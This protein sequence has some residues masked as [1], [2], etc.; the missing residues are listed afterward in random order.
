MAQIFPGKVWGGAEQYV[1]DLGRALVA[2]GHEVEY[3]CLDSAPVISRLN[4]ENIKYKVISSSLDGLNAS[5]D[6]V[7]IHDTRYVSP[8]IKR[9]AAPTK[10]VLTRH[11]AR[12]SRVMPWYRKA[13][14]SLHAMIFVSHLS[15]KMWRGVNSWMPD[16][17][18]CVI[19]NSI[20]EMNPVEMPD[21]RSRFGIGSDLPLL[22]FTGR[23]RRS[24]GCAVI[25][26]A[27]PRLI[28][29]CAVVFVGT[30]KPADY[31]QKL[32]RLAER[33]G[34]SDRIFFYGFT[35]AV[36]SLLPQADIGVQP[37]IVREAFG[38]SQLEFMQAGRPIVTTDNGAQPEYVDDGVTGMLIRP[39]DPEALAE[40]LNRLLEDYPRSTAE[41]GRAAAEA[42]RHNFAYDIFVSNILKVYND[43]PSAI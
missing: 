26:E 41:M 39:D 5:A 23:V 19:H 43:Q 38:L 25:V 31:D 7:H 10:V 1:L 2:Q 27:L 12:A 6:V 34:C 13:F 4:A 22:M 24:K 17:K 30:P 15:E 32:K 11:I 40:A 18:C 35:D 14:R 3:Y 21:L 36:R 9:T 29:K 8:A 20:P 42:Y 16:E 28:R 33:L 37:S